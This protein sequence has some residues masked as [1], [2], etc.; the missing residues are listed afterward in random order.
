MLF[1]GLERAMRARRMP[2][3]HRVQQQGLRHGRNGSVLTPPEWTVTRSRAEGVVGD[4]DAEVER[5]ESGADG[6][7]CQLHGPS[8]FHG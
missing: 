5:D 6:E 2:V 3:L 7:Q 4:E 1:R 8:L